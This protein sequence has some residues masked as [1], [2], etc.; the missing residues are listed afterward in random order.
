MLVHFSESPG[1]IA[2][3]CPVCNPEPEHIALEYRLANAHFA[4]LIGGLSR[5]RAILNRV[6]PW[7]HDYFS[8]AVEEGRCEC[9]NCGRPARLQMLRP[10]WASSDS[11][12]KSRMC[13]LCEA[14]G[15]GVSAS[16]GGQVLALPQVQHFWREHPRMRT[17]PSHVLESEGRVAVVTSFQAVGGTARL[18][19]VSDRDTFRVLS[20]HGTLPEA[21]GK[22]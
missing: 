10:E 15:E 3:R 7:V 5:P 17:L 16:L 11:E 1:P 2:F 18:D 13:M 21:W 22:S 19:V 6:Y 8:R 12:G 14:C 4:R 9:T 20:V